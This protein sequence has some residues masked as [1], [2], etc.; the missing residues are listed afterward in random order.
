MNDRLTPA[1]LNQSA[2]RPIGNRP[3]GGGD[4]EY[5]PS[6]V[7][8]AILDYSIPGFWAVITSRSG[9]RYAFEAVHH[10]ENGAIQKVPLTWYGVEGTVSRFHAVPASPMLTASAGDLVRMW[11]HPSGY[12]FVFI[13]V[14]PS[15]VS[16]VSPG[17][18]G[19]S[20]VRWAYYTRI[21]GLCY[22]VQATLTTDA[23]GMMSIAYD[24]AYSGD[25]P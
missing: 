7:G 13:P 5:I 11:P 18:G 20:R 21:G 9:S 3:Q 1:N 22:F 19:M 12:Y 25:G 10:T 8:P 4:V 16:G 24:L 2:R 6:V 23:R 17:G 15:S 14:G